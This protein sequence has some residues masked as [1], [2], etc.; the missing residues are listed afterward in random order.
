NK[1]FKDKVDLAITAYNHTFHS[2]IGCSPIEAIT[3]PFETKVYEK[4][5]EN[6]KFKKVKKVKN[7]LRYP[8]NEKVRIA[9]YD[10]ITKN[11]KGRFV[12]TGK[13]KGNIGYDSY[14]VQYD[15]T[16]KI[17]KKR[18]H[19]LKKLTAGGGM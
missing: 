5:Q 17:T 14:L 16:N 10:N 12:K 8:Y 19:C 4:N 18:S 11:W 6:P 1:S 15:D 2:A 13:I 7:K 9:Q 3:N